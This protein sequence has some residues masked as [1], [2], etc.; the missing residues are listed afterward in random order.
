MGPNTGLASTKHRSDPQSAN[1]ATHTSLGASPRNKAPKTRH[2]SLRHRPRK[3]RQR[4]ATYQPEASPQEKAPTARTYTSLGHRPRKTRHVQSTFPRCRRPEWS[5]RRNDRICLPSHPHQRQPKSVNDSPSPSL[6][7]FARAS[8]KPPADSPSASQTP[9][10][11]PFPDA[12]SPSSSCATPAAYPASQS[13][14]P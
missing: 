5:R 12:A 14:S 3:K 9:G 1:G 11:P 8:H 2:T 7:P 10:T 4:R 13:G 6:A